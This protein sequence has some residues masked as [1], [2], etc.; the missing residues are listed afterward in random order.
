MS[1]KECA[2]AF[3]GGSFP[4]PHMDRHSNKQASRSDQ[5]LLLFIWRNQGLGLVALESILSLLFPTLNPPQWAPSC[6]GWLF[7]C[8]ALQGYDQSAKQSK[9]LLFPSFR[10]WISE[11]KLPR[12]LW[13]QTWS[14]SWFNFTQFL[15]PYH[16]W[17]LAICKDFI[18]TYIHLWL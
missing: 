17:I 12:L 8:Y 10:E 13:L 9:P 4:L 16:Q 2:Y 7:F 1:S 5:H 6:M 15:Y 3:S 11:G 14:W 18:S